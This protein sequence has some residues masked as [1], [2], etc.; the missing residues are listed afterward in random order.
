MSISLLSLRQYA[1]IG[2]GDP[3]LILIHR[4]SLA[5]Y[6]LI[7]KGNDNC[8]FLQV[9]S[10]IFLAFLFLRN[11]NSSV[12]FLLY[13]LLKKCYNV[14]FWY[15]KANKYKVNKHT[16]A[17]AILLRAAEF[18]LITSKEFL[19]SVNSFAKLTFRSKYT[20]T[21]IASIVKLFRGWYTLFCSVSFRK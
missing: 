4:F 19:F 18:S 17:W 16:D 1:L 9:L 2:L 15:D 21:T 3:K 5:S 10:F 7:I 6:C 8:K 14:P 12:K 13:G 11:N 20:L